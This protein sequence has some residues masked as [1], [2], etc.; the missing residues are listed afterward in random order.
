M[1]KLTLL[2]V[3]LMLPTVSSYAQGPYWYGP[4]GG[5]QSYPYAQDPLGISRAYGGPCAMYGQNDVLCLS[6]QLKQDFPNPSEGLEGV[7]RWLD[8]EMLRLCR[9]GDLSTCEELRQ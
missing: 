4:I 6:E 9:A 3:G 2:L 5:N 8:R 1:K 7:D